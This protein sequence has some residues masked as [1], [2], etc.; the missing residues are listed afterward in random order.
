MTR[1]RLIVASATI[2]GAALGLLVGWLFNFEILGAVAGAVIC[3]PLGQALTTKRRRW[4]AVALLDTH[5]VLSYIEGGWFGCLYAIAAS[6]LTF[7]ISA[8]ILRQFY[9]DSEFRALAHHLKVAIGLTRGFQIIEDGKSVVPKDSTSPMGPHFIIIRPNNA[10]ILERGPRRTRISGPAFLRSSPF[11]YVKCIYDLRQKQ[12]SMTL[13]NVL[14]SDLMTTSVEISMTY[15][16]GIPP[17]TRRG[18]RPLAR[19]EMDR[20]QWI[21]SHMPDWEQETKDTIEGSIRRAVGSWSLDDLLA[22]AALD[23]LENQILTLANRKVSP[24]GIQI[25][26]G[27]VKSV[28]PEKKVTEASTNLRLADAEAAVMARIERARAFAWRDALITLADG[29][30]QAVALG[31]SETAIH[32]EL[33][34]RMLEQISKDPATKLILTPELDSTLVNL[35]RSAGLNP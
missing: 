4:I 8:A 9:G 21:D 23:R 1:A 18:E 33:L 10:V 3:L 26:Q 30:N 13:N 35:R 15:G 12:T 20:I 7:F 11:E 5:F 25:S 17:E 32:R 29:Y 19:A 6:A 2:L 14:T 16:I 27:I 31:I 24:W 22:H 34:R 28:Q